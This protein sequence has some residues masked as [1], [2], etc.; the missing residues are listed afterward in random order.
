MKS[1][2]RELSQMEEMK[3][4]VD[5]IVGIHTKG[6]KDYFEKETKIVRTKRYWYLSFT[7]YAITRRKRESKLHNE[8]KNN[9]SSYYK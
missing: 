1:I 3:A 9:Q 6:K 4:K 7:F 2:K 5:I 8:S